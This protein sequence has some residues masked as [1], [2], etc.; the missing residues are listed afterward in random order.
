[1]T[2]CGRNWEGAKVGAEFP[3]RVSFGCGA[4]ARDSRSL[5]VARSIAARSV[6]DDDH[7]EENF[8]RFFGGRNLLS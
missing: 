6:G 7:S 3:G 2:R 1:M 5:P 4:Q 8:S